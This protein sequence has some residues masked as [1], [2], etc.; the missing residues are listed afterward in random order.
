MDPNR[1]DVH[2]HVVPPFY[3]QWLHTHG[4]SAGGRAIPDWSAADSLR[5]MDEIGV[6]TAILS[7]S[8][9]GVE[10]AAVDR[11]PSLA[12]ELNE[13]CASVVRAD[14]TR[15]GFWATV[16]LPDVDGALKTTAPRRSNSSSSGSKRRSPR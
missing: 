16:T 2:H 7:V 13:F 3:Q 15:F 12:R 11:R 9:P 14:P 5:L 6:E 10:P 4:E 8:T 1:I